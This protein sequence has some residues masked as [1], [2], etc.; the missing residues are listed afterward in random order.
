MKKTRKELLRAIVT[1]VRRSAAFTNPI[2]PD[3][4]RNLDGRL[5]EFVEHDGF[6]GL[7][8]KFGND[9]D[10][11]GCTCSLSINSKCEPSI[12]WSSTSRSPAMART[13]MKYYAQACD[14][15]DEIQ[16]ILDCVTITDEK[17]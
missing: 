17:K 14:L 16:A 5:E 13:A 15:A 1:A 12:S 3:S 9:C 4:A 7:I 11:W 2:N 6:L 10:L 8:I